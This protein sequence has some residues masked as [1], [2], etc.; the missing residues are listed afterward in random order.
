[1]FLTFQGSTCTL[2]IGTRFLP[3]RKQRRRS[4][5]QLI[6]TFVFATWILQFLIFCSPLFQASSFLLWL[7]RPVCVRPGQKTGR[8]FFFHIAAHCMIDNG[9]N[10]HRSYCEC[11][12][13]PSLCLLLV[14]HISFEPVCEKTNNLGSDQV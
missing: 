4:A 13:Y 10:H 1:M 12:F 8:P 14:F 6:S 3:M 2:F 9:C 5:S 7:Y 11:D